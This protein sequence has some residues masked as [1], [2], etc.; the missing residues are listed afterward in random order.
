M[1]IGIDA[2]PPVDD[3]LGVLY[4]FDLDRESWLRG[5]RL[6][7]LPP[8]AVASALCL[9]RAERG[10]HR[11]T[12]AD[13][14]VVG[15]RL[16]AA[17]THARPDGAVVLAEGSLPAAS[18]ASTQSDVMGYPLPPPFEAVYSA[19]G[20]SDSWAV[21]GRSPCGVSLNYCVGF[22]TRARATGRARRYWS[23]AA[24]HFAAAARLRTALEDEREAVLAPDGRVLHAEGIAKGNGQREALRLAAKAIDRARTRR[25]DPLLAIESWT[26]LVSGRWSL[27]DEFESD[28][29]RFVIARVENEPKLTG[30]AALSH[31]ERQ[32]VALAA[33]GLSNKRIA[34]DLGLEA[35]TIAGY[36]RRARGKL[37]AKDRAALIAKTSGARST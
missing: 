34:Y 29:R 10:G 28:G 19:L 14:D 32:V 13:A 4:R 31:R 21:C 6:R 33:M 7:V 37:G 9:V 3:V 16:L 25:D 17:F 35:S 26:A 11:M 1:T 5:L 27:V 23:A 18:L 8:G 2:T 22:A 30:Y 36:L 12:G 15:E 20:V 24:Q